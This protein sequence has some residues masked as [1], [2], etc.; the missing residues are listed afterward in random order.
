MSEAH[1]QAAAAPAVSGP[2][3]VGATGMWAFLATDAM[4]FG[5]LFIAYGVLRVRA[6]S[7]PDP[8][9]HLSLT[10]AAAMTFALLASAFTMTQATRAAAA[11]ARLAWLGATVGLGLAF[12]YGEIAEYRH[13]A[14]AAPMRLRGGDLYAGTFYAL[15]GYHGLHVAAGVVCLLALARGSARPRSLE[16]AA[17]YWQFVDL[18][19][20]PI[21][22]FVYLLPAR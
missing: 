10:L 18:A 5:G 21:F 22:T 6:A 9:A 12:L 4:G 2:S 17:L 20:M 11:R 15:T 14:A 13:L 19:W 7:W 16:V 3:R 8:R 1:T